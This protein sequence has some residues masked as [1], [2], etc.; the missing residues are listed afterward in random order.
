VKDV[1]KVQIWDASAETL[2]GEASFGSAVAMRYNPASARAIVKEG[3]AYDDT[4]MRPRDDASVSG[5]T[6]QPVEYDD[7]T[8]HFRPSQGQGRNPRGAPGEQV[9]YDDAKMRPADK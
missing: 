9:D 8:M 2:L 6:Y 1:M 5:T 3:L 7:R 4:R